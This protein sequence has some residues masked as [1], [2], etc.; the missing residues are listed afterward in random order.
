MGEFLFSYYFLFVRLFRRL[1]CL[2]SAK[3]PATGTN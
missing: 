3:C 1:T 2:L